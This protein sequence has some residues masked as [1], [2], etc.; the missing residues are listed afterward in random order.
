MPTAGY[1]LGVVTYLDVLFALQG[2]TLAINYPG[3]AYETVAQQNGVYDFLSIHA[4]D[5]ENLSAAGADKRRMSDIV[6]GLLRG[7]IYWSLS[8]QGNVRVSQHLPHP[9]DAPV[10]RIPV[11]A[12]DSWA[13]VH[14]PHSGYI[15][16]H[17]M[18]WRGMSTSRQ[19]FET[20]LAPDWVRSQWGAF[21]H[22]IHDLGFIRVTNVVFG[23]YEDNGVT[24]CALYRTS[25]APRPEQCHWYVPFTGDSHATLTWVSVWGPLRGCQFDNA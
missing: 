7:N 8:Y 6:G 11:K 15:G 21:E 13:E 10:S 25:Y 2:H 4:D 3:P 23:G 1:S 20:R 18:K 17:E 12:M 22:A 5:Q 19:A 14:A 16:W 9:A 24:R